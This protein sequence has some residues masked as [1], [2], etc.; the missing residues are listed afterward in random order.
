M[1]DIILQR[2]P[3]YEYSLAAVERALNNDKVDALIVS[4]ASITDIYYIARRNLKDKEETKKL[5]KDILEFIEISSVTQ[6]EII[7]ALDSEFSDFEDSVINEVAI[8]GGADIIVTRNT[9]DFS[10]SILKITT[11]TELIELLT[12]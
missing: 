1:L 6:S 3:F 9:N 5:L 2:E 4:A 7:R 12:E 11:P 10:K 8:S